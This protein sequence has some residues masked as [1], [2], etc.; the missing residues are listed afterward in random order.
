MVSIGALL[1]ITRA[2][3][4]DAELRS[5]ANFIGSRTNPDVADEWLRKLGWDVQ[6]FEANAGPAR[7]CR[8]MGETGIKLSDL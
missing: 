4:I 8:K 7:R 5:E 6:R 3:K 1:Q 2:A